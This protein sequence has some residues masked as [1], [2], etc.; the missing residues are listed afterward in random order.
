MYDYNEDELIELAREGED[1]ALE[2]LWNLDPELAREI[3][4]EL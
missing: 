4:E 1:W 2:L 3:Q